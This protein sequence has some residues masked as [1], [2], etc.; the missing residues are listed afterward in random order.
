MRV[1]PKIAMLLVSMILGGTTCMASGQ[2][3]HALIQILKRGGCSGA[4]TGDIHFTTLGALHCPESNFR[5]IYFEWYGPA[6]PSSHRAQYR[7]LFLEGG[8]RYLG[9]YIITNKPKLISHNSILSAY[10]DPSGV[11]TCAEIGPD[12]SVEFRDGGSQNFEK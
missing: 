12:K 6:H 11:I 8:N 9:S 10:D 3:K 5:V 2:S 1:I 7:L 4:L